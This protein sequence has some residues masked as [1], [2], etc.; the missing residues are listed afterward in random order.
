MQAA[1]HIHGLETRIIVYLKRIIE[2]LTS[3][4]IACSAG[5]EQYAIKF[6]TARREFE[7]EVDLYRDA[8]LRQLL[9]AMLHASD[10][11]D[12]AVQSIRYVEATNACHARREFGHRD[13]AAPAMLR[14]V[15]EGCRAPLRGRG[16]CS[17][18]R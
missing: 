9:P 2:P 7:L 8:A 17:A 5:A 1:T 6:F 14:H 16:S 10:N 3:P 15:V 4:L 13:L 12:G 18:C 11:A